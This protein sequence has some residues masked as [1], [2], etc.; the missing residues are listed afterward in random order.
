MTRLENIKQIR[1][2]AHMIK[3][4]LM[5]DNLGDLLF[6]QNEMEGLII[7]VQEEL[8]DLMTAGQLRAAKDDYDVFLNHLDAAYAAEVEISAK[9]NKS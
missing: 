9:R 3:E 7:R 1:I 8:P 5:T 4:N 2:L 6:A